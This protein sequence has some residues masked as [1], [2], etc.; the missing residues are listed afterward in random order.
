MLKNIIREQQVLQTRYC[1]AQIDLNFLVPLNPFENKKR[2]WRGRGLETPK[3]GKDQVQV[4]K[5][6]T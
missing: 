4:S 2:G 5:N 6:Q 3:N 1:Q